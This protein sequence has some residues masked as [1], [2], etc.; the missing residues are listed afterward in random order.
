M[1][2]SIWLFSNQTEYTGPIAKHHPGV[3][4]I[5]FAV[6]FVIAAAGYAVLFLLGRR[7]AANR[8]AA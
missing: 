4:D 6:G 5:T 1:G 8:V 2:L 7:R 3:G